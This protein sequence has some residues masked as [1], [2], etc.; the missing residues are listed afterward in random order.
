MY[1]YRAVYSE[2][3][4]IDFYFN[5]TRD[6]K[7][8]KRFFKKLLRSFHVSK[9]RVITVAKNPAYPIATE[10]LKGEK[11]VPVG[12][13]VI[14]MLKKK[15]VYQKVKSVQDQNEFIRKLFGLAS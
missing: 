4:T 13:E 3:N 5:K 1:L 2:G 12:I 14:H 7:T 10:E 11:K 9:P 8:E 6:H 15:Q